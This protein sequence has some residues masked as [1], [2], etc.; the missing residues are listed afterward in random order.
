MAIIQSVRETP[1]QRER[2]QAPHD[3]SLRET[4]LVRVRR[5]V[6]LAD[7]VEWLLEVRV[8]DARGAVADPGDT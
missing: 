8:L 2:Q 6:R 3:R 5:A 7:P 4:P 1:S